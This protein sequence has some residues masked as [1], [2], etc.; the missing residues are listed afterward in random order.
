MISAVVLA[1]AS[2]RRTEDHDSFSPLH[3]KPA[4]QSTLEIALSARVAEVI[5]VTDDLAA[6]RREIKLADDRLFWHWAPSSRARSASVIAGLW[7]SHPQSAGVM[8]ISGE[9]PTIRKELIDSLI[10]KFES[11]PASIVAASLAGQPR[12]PILVRRRLFPELLKLTGD[13]GVSSLIAKHPTDTALVD[14]R[15]E[16]PNQD[17]E[18]R[19]V[20]ERI[21]ERV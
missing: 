11:D 6:A 7:A 20:A 15:D 18:R 12:E 21:K 8:F 5:C 9:Q 1:T 14:G 2:A 16:T 4:L 13:E 3:G 10:A 17:G 19:R